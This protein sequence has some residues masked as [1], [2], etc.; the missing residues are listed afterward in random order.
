MLE[1]V[2]I[3]A[4]FSIVCLLIIQY[5]HGKGRA[6]AF[7]FLDIHCYYYYFCVTEPWA[8]LLLVGRKKAVCM[9]IFIKLREFSEG[10]PKLCSLSKQTRHTV[11]STKCIDF[12]RDVFG[13]KREG[14]NFGGYY[15]GT[16]LSS[17]K[18]NKNESP[19]SDPRAATSKVSFFS[20]TSDYVSQRWRKSFLCK[21]V[22][23]DC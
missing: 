4:E 8:G 15:E 20:E 12:V 21:G 1:S 3:S 2:G 19:G 22:N 16:F 11:W 17:R 18:R 9:I 13:E 6:M 5:C 23:C 7:H 14:F 10:G